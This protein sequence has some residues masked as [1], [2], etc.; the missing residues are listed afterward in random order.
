MAL[1]TTYL[2]FLKKGAGYLDGK[3]HFIFADDTVKSAIFLYVMRNRGN[4][5][6]APNIFILEEYKKDIMSW[7]KYA[8][9]Y[10]GSLSC[11]DSVEWIKQVANNAIKKNVVLV[12]F[13]KDAMHC[14]RTL[15]AKEIVRTHP[16]VKYE[17]ELHS[18]P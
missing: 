16:D 15:L 17:G 1:Y 11:S 7:D 3:P 9:L 10:T 2:S 4:N 5:E 12:C 13:E 8:E 6:V 18:P 14:H